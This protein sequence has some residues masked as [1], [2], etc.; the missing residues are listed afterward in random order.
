[1]TKIEIWSFI[2]YSL[3]AL[4]IGSFLN[5]AIY[6]IPNGNFF[7]S[8]RSYCPKCNCKIRW[9]HNIPLFSF[10]FLKGKCASCKEG[11]SIRYPLV[12]LFNLLSWMVVFLVYKISYTTAI[13]AI[14][15]SILIVVSLIDIDTMLIPNGAVL[16]ILLLAIINFAL[17]FTKINNKIL[18]VLWYEHLI[19]T[20]VVSGP[21]FILSLFNLMGM[22]DVKLYFALGLLLGWKLIILSFIIGIIIGA[23]ISLFI[24]IKNK[25]IERKVEIPFG[26]FLALGAFIS[27]L[28][29]KLIINKYV[30]LLLI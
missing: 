22:G 19:G 27:M 11:I 15:T 25:K 2:F 30:V 16:F 23:L 20:V 10:L 24:V 28:I 8:Q 5:V 4:A 6:R 7:S 1:M 12:E 9:Y 18:N 17:S 26:P 3:L 21:L 29:G 14:V 13:F